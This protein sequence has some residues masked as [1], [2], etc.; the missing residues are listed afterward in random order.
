MKDMDFPLLKNG[1]DFILSAVKS[2]NG[3]PKGSDVKYAILHLCSGFEL[4][5]KERL[6][7]E[8][9]VLLVDKI[10][11]ADNTKYKAG[12]FSSADFASCISRLEKICSV[13]FEH[14]EKEYF[15]LLRDKRNKIEHFGLTESHESAI[16]E[17]I[18]GISIIID[19]IRKEIGES[20][21]NSDEKQIFHQIKQKLGSLEGYVAKRMQII[22]PDLLA[23]ADSIIQCPVCKQKA[24]VVGEEL[25]CLFCHSRPQPLVDG[26]YIENINSS[27]WAVSQ[28]EKIVPYICFLFAK[29]VYGKKPIA[30]FPSNA[31]WVLAQIGGEAALETLQNY[32]EKFTHD[33][34]QY[35][36]DGI[37]LRDEK[38][39]NSFAVIA[40]E[41]MLK[42]EP[43]Y[44]STTIIVLA[45]G[46]KVKVLERS[47]INSDEFSGRGVGAIYD[48]IEHIASGSVGY[49]KK[50]GD[51]F[52][53]YI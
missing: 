23:K 20:E 50:A 4:L 17:A 9:W 18:K 51:N 31:I 2:L 41:R 32:K 1:L 39:D 3:R 7:R 44:S 36:I 26:G 21:L 22:E 27:F 45:E 10:D 42:S 43:S 13:R 35:G 34:I 29:S 49:I 48:K 8:H 52:P 40:E 46:E 24:L 5:F 47:I 37:R 16:L 11:N 6:R 38:Q 19:F 33:W 30:A 28:G 12:D 14:R 25:R 15:K 53:S